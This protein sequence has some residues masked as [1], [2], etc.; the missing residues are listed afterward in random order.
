LRVQ[1]VR[2]WSIRL[3]PDPTRITEGVAFG[4]ADALL[5]VAIG[6]G[7][8]AHALLYV[9]AALFVLR[10]PALSLAFARKC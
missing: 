10:G 5:Q 2:R 4:I 6:R 1:R 7:R 3:K 8:E 9:F